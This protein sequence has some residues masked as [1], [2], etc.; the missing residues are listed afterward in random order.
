MRTIVYIDG[1]NFYF[2]VLRGTDYKDKEMLEVEKQRELGY[3]IWKKNH[4]K[5]KKY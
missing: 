1:F 5:K 3:N 2:G 4:Q